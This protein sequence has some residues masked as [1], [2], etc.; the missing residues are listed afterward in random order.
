MVGAACQLPEFRIFGTSVKP[1][2][3]QGWMAEWSNNSLQLLD[4]GFSILYTSICN[5]SNGYIPF[6]D[7]EIDSNCYIR[8]HGRCYCKSEDHVELIDVADV[9]LAFNSRNRSWRNL[10]GQVYSDRDSLQ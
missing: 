7:C 1:G 2:R 9:S 3:T 8:Q 5:Q 10:Y 6:K 4:N